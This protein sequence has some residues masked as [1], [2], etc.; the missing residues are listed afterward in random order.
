MPVDTQPPIVRAQPSALPNGQG[1]YTTPITVTL[2][3]TDRGSGLDTLHV[4]QP[5]QPCVTLTSPPTRL[6]IPLAEE[7]VHVLTVTARDRVNHTT[8][9]SQ[10]YRLDLFPPQVDVLVPPRETVPLLVRRPALKVRWLGRDTHAIVGYDVAVWRPGEGWRP[11]YTATLRTQ[12]MYVGKAGE[13][14][15]FRARAYDAAGWIGPW[16]RPVTVTFPF[17][18]FVPYIAP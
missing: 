5:P 9:L 6:Q 18:T 2:R 7:G 10:T 16:S 4:C 15:A 8:T 12:G 14:V 3:I 11:W 1:W 13:T 17:W